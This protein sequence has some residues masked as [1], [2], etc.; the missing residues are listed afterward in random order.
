MSLRSLLDLF[1]YVV[2]KAGRRR[3][4]CSLPGKLTMLP[5]IILQYILVS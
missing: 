5:N 1:A 2:E 3:C 4:A